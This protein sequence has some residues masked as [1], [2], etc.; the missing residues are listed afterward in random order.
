MEKSEDLANCQTNCC[1]EPPNQTINDRARDEAMQCAM[2]FWKDYRFMSN[3]RIDKQDREQKRQNHPKTEDAT[4]FT[5]LH[6]RQLIESPK[7]K[8]NQKLECKVDT[9]G[10][11]ERSPTDY[12]SRWTPTKE[13]GT[14]RRQVYELHRA[15]AQDRNQFSGTSSFF[16]GDSNLATTHYT[17]K[18]S[19]PQT[20]SLEKKYE[21]KDKNNR[22]DLV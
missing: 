7:R 4:L 10:T 20:Q 1:R 17:V 22:Q 12:E 2:I 15:N 19:Y 16:E 6:A 3:D 11:Q 5:K 8:R 13:S 9:R 18:K 21:S 14:G